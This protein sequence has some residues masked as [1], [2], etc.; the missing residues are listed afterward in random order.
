MV[1]GGRALWPPNKERTMHVR[2]LKSALKLLASCLTGVALMWPGAAN[3]QEH[4]IIK[5]VG[6]H[7]RYS[8]E[9]EPHFAAGFIAP[10]GGANGLGMGG[11]F[12]IPV[13]ANGFIPNINNS[14]AIGFGLD[15]LHYDGCWRNYAY[16]NCS[17]MNAFWFPAV[18]QWNFYFTP[19]WSAFAE[20]GLAMYYVSW[21]DDCYDYYLANGQRVVGCYGS[22]RSHFQFD[23][24][25]QV[26]GRFH[27][28]EKV[29]I[30]ARLG[31]PY[32]SIGVS[33]LL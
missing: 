7:E 14:V 24:V 23:P 1:F 22:P 9:I 5:N 13:V 16:F 2:T 33:F 12:S 8:V 29:A 18:M 28:T 30:T 27:A 31:Y 3:A 20:P 25:F 4:Q 26:G 21:G 10:L 19:H 11:R 15:W 32:F 17:N 6:D